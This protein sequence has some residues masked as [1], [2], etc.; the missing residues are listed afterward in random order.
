MKWEYMHKKFDADETIWDFDLN[1]F[2]DEGWEICGI[3]G[4]T[5]K[6][7]FYFKRPIKN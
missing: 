4:G 2:G 3:I 5:A 1:K 7:V 6:I